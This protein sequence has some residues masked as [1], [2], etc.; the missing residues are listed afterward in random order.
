MSCHEKSFDAR[1]GKGIEPRD[2]GFQAF[3]NVTDELSLAA[4]VAIDVAFGRFDGSVAREQL[5]VAQAASGA[6][7]IAGGDRDETPSPGMRRAPLKTEF[8]EK[9]DEPVDH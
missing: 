6:M 5:D 7:D 9:G 4:G 2:F 3:L 1:R 8:F